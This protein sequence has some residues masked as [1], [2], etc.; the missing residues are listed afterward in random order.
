MD[1]VTKKLAVRT[2]VNASWKKWRDMA[3]LLTDK[4]IPLKIRGSVY[5]SSIRPVMLY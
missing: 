2:R 5:E 3:S 1:E 4:K